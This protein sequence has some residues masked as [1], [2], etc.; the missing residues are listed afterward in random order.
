LNPT[1]VGPLLN[2]F[3]ASIETDIQASEYGEFFKIVTKAKD[4][5]INSHSV[6]ADG[7]NPLLSVPA[8]STPYRGAYVLI[9]SKAPGDWSVVQET[10]KRWIEESEHPPATQEA[11]ASANPKN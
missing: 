9:P 2:T 3:G 10:V 8:D 5:K 11:T 6:S 4:A 7:D 1:K